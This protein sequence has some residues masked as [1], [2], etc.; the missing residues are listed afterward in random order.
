[1]WGE[2]GRNREKKIINY[3]VLDEKRIYFQYAEK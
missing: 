2:T 3:D 1:M